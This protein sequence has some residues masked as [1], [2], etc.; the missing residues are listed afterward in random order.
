MNATEHEGLNPGLDMSGEP[1]K[2]PS[3]HL[4]CGILNPGLQPTDGDEATC[5]RTALDP[6][7][8]LEVHAASVSAGKQM[9]QIRFS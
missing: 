7:E 1:V 8:V 5:G 6:L 3:R 9:A 4:A 2:E